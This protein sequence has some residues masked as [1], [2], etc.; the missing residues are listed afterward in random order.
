MG[1]IS[2]ADVFQIEHELESAEEIHVGDIIQMGA[3]KSP[4]YSVIAISGDKVWVRNLQNGQDTLAP[5]KRC[6]RV[7][8]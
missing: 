6:R 2:Y 8:P 1:A 7:V 3:N 5:L 4:Q